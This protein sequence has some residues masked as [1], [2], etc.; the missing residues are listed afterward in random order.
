MHRNTCPARDGNQL[1]ID[2]EWQGESGATRAPPYALLSRVD[3]SLHKHED[4][5][6]PK[7][8]PSGEK[9][10]GAGVK[11]SLRDS[12]KNKND[13]QEE[14]SHGKQNGGRRWNRKGNIED[15][16]LSL[17]GVRGARDVG[18]GNVAGRVWW[19]SWMCEVVYFR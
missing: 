10:K 1:T 14:K 18:F 17:S 19:F 13:Y 2:G 16:D 5:D 11:L 6:E 4:L 8:L 12:D 15:I 9:Q 3:L 7:G